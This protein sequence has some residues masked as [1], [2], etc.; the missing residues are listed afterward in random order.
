VPEDV[1]D[2]KFFFEMERCVKL[3]GADGV[4]LPTAEGKK[5]VGSYK[6]YS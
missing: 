5:W 6:T 3:G 1:G 2:L 4:S